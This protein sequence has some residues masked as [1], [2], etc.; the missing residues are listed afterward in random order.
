[1]K[2]RLEIFASKIIT[3]SYTWLLL[4]KNHFFNP[5]T[6][7]TLLQGFRLQM[8]GRPSFASMRWKQSLCV[9]LVFTWSEHARRVSSA[10]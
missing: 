10:P 4:F 8:S 6:G 9:Q 5:Q 1:M 7:A 3:V 2:S